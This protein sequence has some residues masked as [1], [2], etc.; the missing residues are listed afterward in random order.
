MSEDPKITG[1][2][3][4]L[5]SQEKS[6]L[7]G[8]EP[9]IMKKDG[10]E[11]PIDPDWRI[12]A[13]VKSLKKSLSLIPAKDL[14]ENILGNSVYNFDKE[15]IIEIDDT[16]KSL[17]LV[18]NGTEIYKADVRYVFFDSRISSVFSFF[19]KREG[20]KPPLGNTLYLQV[21]VSPRGNTDAYQGSVGSLMTEHKLRPQY[22]DGYWTTDDLEYLRQRAAG[23]EINI[24]WISV[25]R[26]C[27]DLI[28]KKYSKEEPE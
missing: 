27:T 8:K 13:V 2:E 25:V 28:N 12:G 6:E 15:G 22:V 4:R 9:V 20:E 26:K 1:D 7:T 23:S 5:G 18:K 16:L 19:F 17:G 14:K 24:N 21:Q 3:P 10:V 11:M